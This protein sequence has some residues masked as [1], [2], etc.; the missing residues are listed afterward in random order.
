MGRKSIDSNDLTHVLTQVLQLAGL[1]SSS[2]QRDRIQVVKPA[3]YHCSI[4]DISHGR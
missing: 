4:S 2:R 3:R 1:Q